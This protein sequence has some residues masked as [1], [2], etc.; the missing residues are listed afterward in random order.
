ML[1][2]CTTS[3]IK[4]ISCIDDQDKFLDDFS[5]DPKTKAVYEYDS[6]SETL[7]PYDTGDRWI[8]IPPLKVALT[9]SGK[10]KIGTTEESMSS[11]EIW[12]AEIVI[13]LKAMT[14]KHTFT[15]TKSLLKDFSGAPRAEWRA[16]ADHNMKV[17]ESDRTSVSTTKTTEGT[18]K[19]LKPLT[20]TVSGESAK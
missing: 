11:P 16:I 8:G 20:T 9:D 4:R 6:F 13:D 1:A 12:S 14:Y 3:P 15:T 10:V 19:F 5:Y 2:S 17:L 18:C 7:I